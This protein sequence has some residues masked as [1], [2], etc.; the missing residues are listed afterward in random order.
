MNIFELG[1]MYNKIAQQKKLL[2]KA[3]KHTAESVCIQTYMEQVCTKYNRP[4]TLEMIR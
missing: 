3:T 2:L 1:N 4:G